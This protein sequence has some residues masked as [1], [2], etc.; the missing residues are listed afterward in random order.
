MNQ[1]D[2]KAAY[3]L[4]EIGAIDDR[5]IAEA[6]NVRR[7]PKTGKVLLILA[8]CIALISILLIS[9]AGAFT[10]GGIVGGIIRDD[11]NSSRPKPAEELGEILQKQSGAEGVTKV[12]DA[13]EIDFFN[14]AYLIWQ[15]KSGGYCLKKLP[16][17]SLRRLTSNI[18]GMA[19]G[20][21]EEIT[22][23]TK[24]WISCGDGTVISPYLK[25]SAGN[26]GYGELFN[27]EP[28]IIPSKSFN[29]CVSNLFG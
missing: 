21:D 16:D 28:E 25:A 26:I 24:V 3:L 15:S 5:Y 27:Y 9:V 2:K 29:S 8:A 18:G 19:V 7:K 6:M 12:A 20:D 11:I 14:G 13:S 4:D 23:G 22:L 10:I 17:Y 1:K